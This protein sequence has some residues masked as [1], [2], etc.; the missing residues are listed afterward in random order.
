MFGG[1]DFVPV[2]NFQIVHYYVMDVAACRWCARARAGVSHIRRVCICVCVC[3][4]EVQLVLVLMLVCVVVC[5]IITYTSFVM[6]GP[7][8][9]L[10]AP[11]VIAASIDQQSRSVTCVCGCLCDLPSFPTAC[12]CCCH[13]LRRWMT[14]SMGSNKLDG[15]VPSSLSA[16]KKLET[17]YA[18]MSRLNFTIVYPLSW[19]PFLH[20]LCT[21]FMTPT[22]LFSDCATAVTYHVPKSLDA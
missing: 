20:V 13:T 7:G 10:I 3:V 6:A 8:S 18:A 19:Y 1:L 9:P 15:S 21:L 12:G 2:Y 4:D 16:L 11:I 22:W 14:R 17:M 5:M